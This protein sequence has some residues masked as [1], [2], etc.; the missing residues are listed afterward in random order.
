MS[1][2][3]YAMMCHAE[4]YANEFELDIKVVSAVITVESGWDN[5][6]VRFEP[7][8]KWHLNVM[9]WAKRVNVS[10]ATET[11][12]QQ[13]SWGLMQVMGTVARELGYEKDLPGLCAPATGIQFG[14]KKLKQNYVRYGCMKKALAAYNAGNPKSKAGQLY[15]EKV[16]SHIT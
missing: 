7:G 12:C 9:Q 8:W 4:R 14:C 10:T 6:A 16:Y 13:M 15:A 5:W 2:E 1:T 3:K 11:I